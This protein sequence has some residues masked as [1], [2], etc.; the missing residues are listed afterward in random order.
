[1]GIIV[2]TGRGAQLGV[3]IKGGEVLEDTRAVDVVVVDKTGTVTEGRM[4]L[5]EVMAPDADPAT[6]LRVAASLE[7][8]SEHPIAQA[9]STAVADHARV[10]D[11]L[12][13]PGL[14]VTGVVDGEPMK[15][16][17]AIVDLV[18]RHGAL[19][20]PHVEFYVKSL[21]QAIASARKVAA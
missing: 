16:G 4:E 13:L 11:F 14:G 2:G 20:A 10:E 5:V 21:A 3:I 6:L 18:A 15:V 7:S 12:N 9:V 17:S 8:L 19:A 1:M